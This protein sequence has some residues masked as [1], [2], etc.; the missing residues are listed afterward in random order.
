MCYSLIFNDEGSKYLRSEFGPRGNVEFSLCIGYFA[1]R[2]PEGWL[3]N[4][5]EIHPL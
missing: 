1:R 4:I 3:S 2:V 5:E